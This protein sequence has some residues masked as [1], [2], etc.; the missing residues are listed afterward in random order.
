[1]GPLGELGMKA[2]EQ[3]QGTILGLALEG[4]N[5]RRQLR[6]QG[7]L[8]EQQAAT[9]R[10][11]MQFKQALD[12]DTWN[13]TNYSSQVD[14]LE[15]AG[16]NPGLLYGMSGGGGSTTGNSSAS[17]SAAKAPQGGQ[18]IMNL[19][20]MGAQKALLEAQTEKTKAEAVKTAGVDTQLTNQ[21]YRLA[22]IAAQLGAETYEAT[23]QKLMDEAKII[24]NEAEISGATKDEQIEI[25][26]GELVGLGLANELKK[27]GITKTEQEIKTMVEQV[28]QRWA[29]LSIQ[30]QNAIINGKRYALEKFVRDIPDSTRITVE[31]IGKIAATATGAKLK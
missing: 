7:K 6:Q 25:K 28:A 23:Y 16:L 4:H 3:V 1:M 9:D 2:A 14:Q 8:N 10:Q 17:V 5:D 30:E 18:E 21:Q 22:N 31:A 11:Q 20:L 13:K 29:E 15:K 24:H 26:E 19:Q 12:I 27:V